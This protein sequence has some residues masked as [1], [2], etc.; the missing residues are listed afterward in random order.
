[1]GS[2]RL[3]VSCAMLSHAGRDGQGDSDGE[4]LPR[5]R[6]AQAREAHLE[7]APPRFHEQIH[8]PLLEGKKYDIAKRLR[9]R[10]VSHCWFLDCLRHGRRL[11][12]G[13]YTM[14]SAEEM[15]E[16]GVEALRAQEPIAADVGGRAGDSTD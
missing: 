10:I 4:R 2:L 16:R 6:S 15:V 5:Q 12:E 13:P 11:P 8:N 9:V 1:M 7:A 14:E 3:R